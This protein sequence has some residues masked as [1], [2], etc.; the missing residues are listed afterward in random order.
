M[1]ILI[2]CGV[3]LAL[4]LL[5]GSASADATIVTPAIRPSSAGT[6]ECWVVN[7]HPTK[8]LQ[9]ELEIRSFSGTVVES[10]SGPVV[11][12][13]ANGI[14]TDADTARFCVVRVTSG[15]RKNAI[16]SLVA[17]DGGVPVSTVVAK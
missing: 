4:S 6:L 14:T 8:Q 10:G 5:A 11:P 13:G 12:N 15:S 1:R 17:F 16:V 3:A 9:V 7:S 2:A